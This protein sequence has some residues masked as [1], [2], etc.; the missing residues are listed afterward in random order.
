MFNE[1]IL[2]C[3]ALPLAVLT[4]CSDMKFVN[5]SEVHSGKDSRE[6]IRL[7]R[8][9][10]DL[11]SA[12]LVQQ[13]ISGSEAIYSPRDGRLVIQSVGV[14]TFGEDN[15]TKGITR[16]DMGLLYLADSAEAAR[17]RKDMEFA[18][19]VRHTMPVKTDPTT[20]SMQLFTQSIVWDDANSRFRCPGAY[21]MLLMPPGKRAIR[22]LGEAFEATQDLSRFTV[23]RGA[24]T[25]DMSSDPR[26]KRAEFQRQFKLLMAQVDSEMQKQET[27]KLPEKVDIPQD[28]L[29]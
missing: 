17:K 11:T 1:Y 15:T 14:H 28:A 23:S 24:V 20:D 16:S 13:R 4:G 5:T 21:E 3:C 29:P 18:G 6:D 26:L 12:G 7:T 8:I 25:T 2:L 19:N 27:I 9:S 22:T 10:T